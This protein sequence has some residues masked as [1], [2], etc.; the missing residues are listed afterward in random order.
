M[1]ESIQSPRSAKPVDAAPTQSIHLIS[2]EFPSGIAWLLNVLLDLSLRITRSDHGMWRNGRNGETLDPSQEELKRWIPCLSQRE[3]FIFPEPFKFHWGH[4]WPPLSERNAPV[5]FFIRNGLD[6]V[7]SHY[8]R[9]FPH[10]SF[11]EYLRHPVVPVYRGIPEIRHLPPAETWALFCLLWK[12][13]LPA[14]T[15][16]LRFEDA[17]QNPIAQVSSLL[18]SFGI[19]RTEVAIGT[20]VEASSF[21]NA[22]KAEDA[23]LSAHPRA[24]D[25]RINRGG[26]TN[27]WKESFGEKE[28]ECFRGLPALAL[29]EFGYE[30]PE[31]CRS[32]QV[33][34]LPAVEASLDL[35]AQGDSEPL[36]PW[37]TLSKANWESQYQAGVLLLANSWASELSADAIE[38]SRICRVLG[39]LA[40]Q[41]EPRPLLL[42]QVALALQGSLDR[43]LIAR[44]LSQA[45]KPNPVSSSEAFSLGQTFRTLGD[46][47]TARWLFS[48]AGQLSRTE[49]GRQLMSEALIQNC[50]YQNA[51]NVLPRSEIGFWVRRVASHLVKRARRRVLFRR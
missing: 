30:V 42:S 10:V 34:W 13:L 8:K 26:R 36:R 24:S 31:G 46:Q 39:E 14:E 12:R 17:K 20:A 21:E 43:G 9:F 15:H 22:R 1:S 38:R 44:F 28:L 19:V 18:R 4:Q 27:E 37:G 48:Q 50:Q 11:L 6:A 40:L 23:Y 29:E 16:W 32:V 47:T 35:L 5:V 45:L 33:K 25:V 49:A 51:W 2:P 7:H 41:M 3:E